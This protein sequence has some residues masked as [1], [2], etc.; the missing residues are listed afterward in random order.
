MGERT[1]GDGDH[2]VLPVPALLVARKVVA[3]GSADG[4]VDPERDTC[5]EEGEGELEAVIGAGE[6]GEVGEADGV[7]G[8]R[9]R[10][11]GRGLDDGEDGEEPRHGRVE[12]GRVGEP[13][14]AVDGEALGGV[15]RRQGDHGHDRGWRAGARR[16]GCALLQE[17][18]CDGGE[19]SEDKRARGGRCTASTESASVAGRE[20]RALVSLGL[21]R[22]LVLAASTWE[23]SS[24]R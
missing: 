9:E 21:E 24:S 7:E 4:V 5:C 6:V 2:L 12:E 17:P 13:E 16:V 3:G 10:P 23:T 14:E 19:A 18:L 1:A 8:G 22:A 11:G 20:E 15:P